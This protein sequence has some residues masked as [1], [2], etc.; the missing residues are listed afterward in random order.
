M[1]NDRTTHLVIVTCLLSATVLLGGCSTPLPKTWLLPADGPIP[2]DRL[3][4][5]PPR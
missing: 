2:I 5:L 4:M 1:G 3:Q